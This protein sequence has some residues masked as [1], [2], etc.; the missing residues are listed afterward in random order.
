MPTVFLSPS[1][2]E[3]NLFITSTGSEEYWMN[4]IIDAMIPYLEASGIQ[5]GRNDP[6]GT[7]GTSVRMSNEGNYDFHLAIH[8]NASPE[9]MPGAFQGPNI[10]YFT[11][12]TLGQQAAEIFANN[13]R[14]IYPNPEL[15]ITVPSTALYE[16]RNT[17]APAVLVEVAYHDNWSDATWIQ[18]NVDAIA[19]AMVLS[20]TEYFGVP[21]VNP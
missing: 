15:V 5:Y 12:S 4:L 18:D 20:L 1:T 3:Y 11:T 17:I 13:F 14:A 19:R 8:S 21:F 16:L 10:Y 7:V 2:Q 9:T 6:E